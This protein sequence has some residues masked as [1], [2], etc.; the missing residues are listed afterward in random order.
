MPLYVEL[1]GRLRQLAGAAGGGMEQVQARTFHAAALRQLSH[2]W[3]RTVGGRPPAVLDSKLSLLTEI[4]QLMLWIADTTPDIDAAFFG[5][6]V[7]LLIDANDFG[8]KATVR[9]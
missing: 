4:A 5:E 2:F 7:V 8:F 6:T 3:P 1:R 9:L